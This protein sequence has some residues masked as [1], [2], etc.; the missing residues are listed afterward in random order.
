[1]APRVVPATTMLA[2]GKGSPV[3]LSVMVPAILPVVPDHSG[4]MRIRAS[5]RENRRLFSSCF[6]M[7]LPYN[8]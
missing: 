3:D 7:A 4:V 6:I 2:P 8:G 5:N 1:M